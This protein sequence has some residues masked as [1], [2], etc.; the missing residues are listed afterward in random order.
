MPFNIKYLSIHVDVGTHRR[1]WDQS[2]VDTK[3]TTVCVLFSY[4]QCL[5]GLQKSIFSF[6]KDIPIATCTLLSHL[7]VRDV[8][9]LFSVEWQ[10]GSYC[11]P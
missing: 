3:G 5:K 9:S 10:T 6:F 2:L 8:S 7:H 1:S 11:R 4:L